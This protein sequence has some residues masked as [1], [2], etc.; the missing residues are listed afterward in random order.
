MP[1]P[2]RVTF[3]GLDAS[4]ALE[5]RVREKAAHLE[6]FAEQIVG[7]HV[8]IEAPHR[9]QRQGLL[10]QTRLDISV[11]GGRIEVSKD[12]PRNHTHEDPMISVRDAFAAAERQLE[13]LTERRNGAVK[14][15]EPRD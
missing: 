15:H 1:I 8:T 12:N 14:N 2:V 10:Y 9:H 5:E 11:R 13:A 4:P 3:K 6:R 7:C